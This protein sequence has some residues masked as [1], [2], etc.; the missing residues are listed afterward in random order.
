MLI[1]IIRK[2]PGVSAQP[3][4]EENK[5]KKLSVFMWGVVSWHAVKCIHVGCVVSW[6]VVKCFMWGVLACS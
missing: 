1:L 4:I 3:G 5:Q 2:L 6:Y